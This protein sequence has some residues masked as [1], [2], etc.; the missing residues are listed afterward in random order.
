M[1]SLYLSGP[2]FPAD[3]PKK[4]LFHISLRGHQ[5]T[6]GIN[7]LKLSKLVNTAVPISLR[8]PQPW[9]PP[10]PL[11]ALVKYHCRSVFV[12]GPLPV[13]EPACELGWYHLSP[14]SYV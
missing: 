13:S 6:F 14:A 12:H 8:I 9:L 1:V 5:S 7:F 4:C 11:G 2:A 10:N 3:G